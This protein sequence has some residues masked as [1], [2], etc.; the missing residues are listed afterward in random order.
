MVGRA[1]TLRVEEQPMTAASKPHLLTGRESSRLPD[2]LFRG[3]SGIFAIAIVVLL[4]AVAGLLAASSLQTW[5]TFGLGFLTG[6]TWDPVAGI[7]GALPFIV[8][9]IVTATLAM[10]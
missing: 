10:V 2:R 9:T 6:I 3:S 1:A 4:I 5:G 7:Y 8:G